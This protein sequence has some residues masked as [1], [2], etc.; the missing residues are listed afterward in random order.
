[1]QWFLFFV[2]TKAPKWSDRNPS[3]WNFSQRDKSNKI[4]FAF[5]AGFNHFCSWDRGQCTNII[6]PSFDGKMQKLFP[7]HTCGQFH[8]GQNEQ[9]F[10][11]WVN[12]SQ[13]NQNMNIWNLSQP[14][15]CVILSK[16]QIAKV[17]SR[18]AFAKWSSFN[19]RAK[20]TRKV[21]LKDWQGIYWVSHFIY[22]LYRWREW[23]TWKHGSDIDDHE[24]GDQKDDHDDDD[25]SLTLLMIMTMMMWVSPYWWWLR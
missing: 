23:W 5:N 9:I 12:K 6:G 3:N 16:F 4:G 15:V 1:M 24:G 11:I 22:L 21:S 7:S 2:A 17:C 25:I 8:R 18:G 19:F 13:K 14:S 10:F 20:D